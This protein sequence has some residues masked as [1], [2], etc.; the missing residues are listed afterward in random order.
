MLN[1]TNGLKNNFL[2]AILVSNYEN[3]EKDM[4]LIM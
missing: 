2:K 1:M 4:F 3:Y